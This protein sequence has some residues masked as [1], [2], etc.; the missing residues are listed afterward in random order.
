M[1]DLSNRHTRRNTR[2]LR[3]GAMLFIFLPR[4]AMA[5]S[6]LC[7]AQVAGG[8]TH[9][10]Q[11]GAWMGASFDTT[12]TKYV[13]RPPNENERR[14]FT[15]IP[16][17]LVFRFGTDYPIVKCAEGFV[18]GISDGVTVG[19]K[20]TIMYCD[21]DGDPF[22]L[23]K[24]NGRYT[25]TS[26]GGYIAMPGPGEKARRGKYSSGFVEGGTCQEL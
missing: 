6:W 10:Q 24:A 9:D 21:T 12:D 25:R 3:V 18:G 19:F 1:G 26:D 11:S 7:I 2:I 15:L 20:P 14:Q 13:V 22:T 8:I 5:E 4:V 16:E 17:Y 23:N